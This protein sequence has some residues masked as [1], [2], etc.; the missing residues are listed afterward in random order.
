MDD[1]KS[2]VPSFIGK[3]GLMLR[4]K[5]S[6]PYVCWSQTGES[7]VVIDPPVFATQVLPRCAVAPLHCLCL[8]TF[9]DTHICTHSH[10]R[11]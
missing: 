10:K 5:A 9:W 2:N 11:M 3:L 1:S 7:V 8:A 6:T 4:D